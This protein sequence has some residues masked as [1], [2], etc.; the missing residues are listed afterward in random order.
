[1]PHRTADPVVAAALLV[2]ALQNIA[3]RF[4]SP[5]EPV[6][7]TVGS[8][9]AGDAFNVIPDACVLKGTVR[10]FSI[11]EQAAVEGH[12]R[13]IASGVGAATDTQMEVTWTVYTSPTVN[14]ETYAGH[15][16]KALE[17]M[18]G[19]DRVLTDYR[20]MAGEDFGEI[21]RVV[22]GCFA[23]VGSGNPGRGLAEPHHSPRFDFDEDALVIAC[24]LHRA[25]A[26]ELADGACW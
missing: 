17:R 14:D 26:A 6:V 22:P 16:K 20:T 5:T 2:V 21:L 1:M 18:T 24:D 12:M 7:V 23:L 10:T 25:V 11:G 15:A 3:S 4:T 8:I 9:H 19:V 13:A